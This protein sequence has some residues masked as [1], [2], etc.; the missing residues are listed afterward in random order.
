MSTTEAL[1]EL[2]RPFV[3]GDEANP[4]DFFSADQMRDYARAALAA[5]APSP[6]AELVAAQLLDVLKTYA[7]TYNEHWVRGMPILEPLADAAIAAAEL[8]LAAPGAH[9]APTAQPVAIPEGCKLV[10]VEMTDDMLH[11]AWRGLVGACDHVTIREAYRRMLRAAPMLNG[12]TAS[13]TAETASFAVQGGKTGWPA[14][15][16]QDDSRELSRAL[17]NTPEARLH[18]REAAAAIARSDVSPNEW[19]LPGDFV[20]CGATF[21]AGVHVRAVVGRMQRL[22]DKAFPG[23]RN[24]TQAQM[25]AN[26]AVLQGEVPAEPSAVNRYCRSGMCVATDTEHEAWCTAHAATPPAREAGLGDA[27]QAFDADAAKRLR[28]ICGLLGLATA[29]PPD[30]ATLM[31]AQFAVFGMMRRAAQELTNPKEV[32]IDNAT[33]HI[34]HEGRPT[35]AAYRVGI[36]RAALSAAAAQEKRNG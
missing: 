28:A 21:R 16:L 14:G 9:P 32:V 19:R 11:E 5:A 30:D 25:D 4:R 20:C 33:R 8:A 10:P 12:L 15:M 7:S 18:V 23:A 24:L 29:V 34:Y 3:P 26:L 35:S 17:S 13:E 2:P 1:P 22:Y 6:A 31:G 36:V 27:S